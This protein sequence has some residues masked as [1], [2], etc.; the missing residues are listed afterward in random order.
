MIATELLKVQNKKG[1]ARAILLLPNF[2]RNQ[3]VLSAV[4]TEE[5]EA[6][7]REVPASP[8]LSSAAATLDLSLMMTPEGNTV[9]L[10]DQMGQISAYAKTQLRGNETRRLDFDQAS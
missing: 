7:R 1:P 2:A 9:D 3:V 6:L 10:F 8:R 5:Q 4:A